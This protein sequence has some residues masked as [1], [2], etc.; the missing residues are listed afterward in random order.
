MSDWSEAEAATAK[1]ISDAMKLIAERRWAKATPAQ[2]AKQGQLMRAGRKK[3]R[4]KR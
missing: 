2:R 3:K 1:A 4:S